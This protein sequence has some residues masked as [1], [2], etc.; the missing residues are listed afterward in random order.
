MKGEGLKSLSF[1]SLI[2]GVYLGGGDRKRGACAGS[3]VD[4]GCSKGVVGEG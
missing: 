2:S 3:K 1:S 4:I